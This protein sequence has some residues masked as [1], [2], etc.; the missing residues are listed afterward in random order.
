M[1][2]QH[3]L[4]YQA[5]QMFHYFLFSLLMQIQVML[6]RIWNY[7]ENYKW[8]HDLGRFIKWN[9]YFAKFHILY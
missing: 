2:V 3:I 7:I 9:K 4:L 1:V 8:R 6:W 5:E